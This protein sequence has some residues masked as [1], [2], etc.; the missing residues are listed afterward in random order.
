MALAEEIAS[1]R[2]Y[3]A[4]EQVRY[5]ERLQVAFEVEPAAESRRVPSFL[6]HPLAENAVKYGIRTSPRPLRV[7]GRGAHRGAQAPGRDREHRALV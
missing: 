1:I 2:R 4:L 3:L 7:R 5:E 6:L